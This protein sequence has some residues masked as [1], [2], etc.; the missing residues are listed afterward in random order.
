MEAQLDPIFQDRIDA[1]AVPGAAAVALDRNGNV[2]FSKGYGNT[3]VGDESSPKVT[4]STLTLI[5]SCTKLVTAV[6]MLQLIEQGK[7]DLMDPASK[8]F[9]PIAKLKLLKGWNEDGTPELV[10]PE[11]EILLLHLFTHT[12]GTGYDFFSG[13]LLRYRV[14]QA[15]PVMTYMTEGTLES[16]MTPLAFEPGTKYQYGVSF[17]F[18]GLCLEKVSGMR[19]D[20]YVDKHIIRPLGLENTGISLNEEQTKNLFPVHAKDAEGKLTPTPTRPK[21]DPEVVGGGHFLYST[22]EDYAQ[23]LLVLLNNGTHPTSKVRILKP[24]TVKDYIFTDMLPKVGCSNEGVGE[25]PSTIPQVSC[26]GTFMPGIPKGWSLGGMI[27]HEDLPNGRKKGSLSWSGLGNLYYWVDRT[28]GYLGMVGS[29]YLPYFDK[30]ALH[31]ADA[32]ERA[33]YGKPMAKEIGEKGSNFEGGN[34]E[35][36]Q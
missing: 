17:D 7:A 2:L 16:F 32:L 34:Y 33:V 22:A 21:E 23:I 6:A 4:P 20:Q 10:E 8:Y 3:T 9:P 26:E 19:L 14:Q 30:D 25:I 28:E 18:L 29:A 31:L 1:K 15:Q 27:N 35:V 11:N 12:S 24:E 36:A 5:F 13:D